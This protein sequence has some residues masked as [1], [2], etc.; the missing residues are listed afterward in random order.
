MIFQNPKRNGYYIN[1]VPKLLIKKRTLL[2]K[3]TN[4]LLDNNVWT[5]HKIEFIGSY[6]K[7][8]CYSFSFTT[9]NE[10]FWIN[11]SLLQIKFK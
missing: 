7:E 11:V 1:S 8:L 6:Q 2:P 5:V 3:K 4:L 9:F 10:D